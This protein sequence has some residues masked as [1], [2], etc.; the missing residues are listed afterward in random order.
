M[1][2]LYTPDTPV[3]V[4]DER[5]YSYLTPDEI[6]FLLA[7]TGIETESVLKGHVIDVQMKAFKVT[8]Q[9]YFWSFHDQLY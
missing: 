9:R 6:A 8:L 3:P 5:W 4:L 7:E 2:V 1:P